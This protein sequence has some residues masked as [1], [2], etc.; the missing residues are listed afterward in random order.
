MRLPDIGD[1]D[2]AADNV[3]GGRLC[4]EVATDVRSTTDEAVVFEDEPFVSSGLLDVA[5]RDDQAT[6]RLGLSDAGIDAVQ[7]EVGFIHTVRQSGSR[8]HD[9]LHD[10]RLSIFKTGDRSIDAEVGHTN[11]HY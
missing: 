1:I 5:A 11:P 8:G 10:H 4:C 9:W 3:R 6:A 7:A 2:R